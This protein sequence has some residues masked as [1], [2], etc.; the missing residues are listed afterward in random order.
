MWQKCTVKLL[1]VL[2]RCDI[3][4]VLVIIIIIIINIIIII[5]VVIIIIIINIIIIIVIIIINIIIINII[6]INIINNNNN[7]IRGWTIW[8]VPS[9]ELQLLSPSFLWSRNCSLSLWAVV[10]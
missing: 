4:V 7:N 8:P 3:P 6:I 10:V 5:I 2:L 9:P 1:T